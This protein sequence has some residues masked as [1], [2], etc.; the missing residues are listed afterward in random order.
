MTRPVGT[1]APWFTAAT[2]SRPDYAFSSVAGRYV[3]MFFLPSDP[4]AQVAARACVQANRAL[5][6]DIRIS[7]FGVLRDAASIAAAQDDAPGLRWFFD[8]DG[9]I[10]RSFGAISP[11]GEEIPIWVLLDTTHRVLGWAPHDRAEGD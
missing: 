2:P 1:P 4:A 10:G 6:D 11:D 5:F 9:A 3:L 8:A 7:A